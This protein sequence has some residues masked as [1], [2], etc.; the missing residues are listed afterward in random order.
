[1][2]LDA[3]FQQALT[4]ILERFEQASEVLAEQIRFA[5]RVD[6]SGLPTDRAS[7]TI[8]ELSEL[9]S[10]DRDTLREMFHAGQFAGLQTGN[11]ILIH[12]WSVLEFLGLADP[13]KKKARRK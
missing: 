9:L 5:R 8:R 13:A 3:A 11:R 10:L 7:F 6:T 1:M 4:P 12:R 2:S